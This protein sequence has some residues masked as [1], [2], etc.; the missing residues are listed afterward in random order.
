M[1]EEPARLPNPYR[2]AGVWMSIVIPLFMALNTWR[3]AS[4]P[5]AFIA[6]FGLPDS[7]DSDPAFVYVYASRA[8]FLGLITAVLV[9]KRQF[10][11]LKYFAGVAIIMPLCDAFQVFQAEGFSAVVVRHLVVATYLAITAMLLHRWEARH[12]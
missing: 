12:G 8:L 10:T 5:S 6:Y 4:D 7:A 9:W 2:S 1:S 3:S 11:A